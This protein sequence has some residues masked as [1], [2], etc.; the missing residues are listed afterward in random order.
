MSQLDTLSKDWRIIDLVNWGKEYFHSKGFENPRKEIEWLLCDLLSLSRVELYLHFEKLVNQTTLH[1]L[2]KWIKRRLK[3]EPL[4]Y[5]TGKTDFF[6]STILLHT[7]AL[8]PRLE[9]EL[10]VEITIDLAKKNQTE[11]ILDIGT[12]TGCIAIALALKLNNC[13]IEA[14]DTSQQVLDLA[15]ENTK[16]NNVTKNITY[17]KLDILNDTICNKYDIVV[18][19]PPYVSRQDYEMLP[20]EIKNYEPK[21]AL[22]DMDDGLKFYRRF[23]EI[24]KQIVNQ[25]GYIVIELGG[26]EHAQKVKQL[27]ERN[28]F[29]EIS[30][31]KD[32]NGDFRVMTVK[33]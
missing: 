10:L 3:G 2:R 13:A 22:T 28:N 8:I 26:N 15:K 21:D 17:T 14:V 31:F 24:G 29:S 16:L 25:D 20:K 4:Q 27:F 30:L 9:T 23:T 11:S 7:S 6:D 12:G 5:I 32:Y 1:N 19:N 33:I 18:S